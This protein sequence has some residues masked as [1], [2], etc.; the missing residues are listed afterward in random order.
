MGFIRNSHTYAALRAPP[1]SSTVDFI[2]LPRDAKSRRP[3]P[4]R[5][6]VPRLPDHDATGPNVMV[7][8]WRPSDESDGV[9]VFRPQIATVA[10]ESTFEHPPSPMSDVVDN[11]AMW[12]DPYN[13]S[14]SVHRA[15][16]KLGG[17]A[18]TDVATKEMGLVKEI[19]TGLVDDLFGGS[20]KLKSAP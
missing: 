8:S 11:A 4:E 18:A 16:N 1:E 13:L 6:M 7:S 10:S 15:A 5:I 19:W 14:R 12:I 9:T 3:N 17:T 2:F 20:P